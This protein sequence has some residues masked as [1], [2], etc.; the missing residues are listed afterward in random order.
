[1]PTAP[2]IR[3]L[4]DRLSHVTTQSALRSVSSRLDSTW[5]KRTTQSAYAHDPAKWVYDNLNYEL[6][7]LQ[8]DVMQSIADGHDTALRTGHGVGKTFV[9]AC[10]TLWWLDTH[11]PS[12][13]ITTAPGE[14][15]LKHILWAEI[16]HLFRRWKRKREWELKASMHL[17]HRSHPEDWFAIGI[18][19]STP[20]NIEGFHTKEKE[21]AH[22]NHNLLAIV[23]EAKGVDEPFFD[24]ITSMQGRRLYASVPPLDGKGYF[25]DACTKNRHAFQQ[26]HMSSE[27]SSVVKRSWLDK[28]ALEWGRDSVTYKAKVKGEIPEKDISNLVV[29]PTDVEAAQARWYNQQLLTYV[30]ALGVDVARYGSDDSVILPLRG[31]RV[32]HVRSHNGQSLTWTVGVVK[33]AADA[34]ASHYNSTHP[35]EDEIDPKHIPIAVDDTGLGGGVTDMLEEQD[36]FA[37]AVNFGSK[38][39]NPDVYNNVR[40][41]L[42]FELADAVRDTLALPP[43]D[44]QSG[45]GGRI[46]ADLLAPMFKYT[47]DKKR[48]ESKE[49]IKKRLGRSP[50]YGDALGLA[51]RA[52]QVGM[53]S[54][55]VVLI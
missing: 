1:M 35:D 42:W 27:E 14:R 29:S 8:P 51:W 9:L 5:Q 6:K 40:N 32:G 38:A 48:M 25:V 28:V 47:S 34:E 16:G 53:G 18:F 49:E 41:E 39:D 13:V 2:L 3:P 46:V 4:T 21:D 37:I 30:P 15:Q 7:D 26:F 50:D 22:E 19:A 43:D 12:K 36:Y 45:I 52:Q 17:Y 20:D 11:Q 33:E 10:T 24:A 54:G 23:D 44:H 31:S 55:D